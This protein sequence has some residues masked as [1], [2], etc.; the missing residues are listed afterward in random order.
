MNEYYE[1]FSPT[2]A[3]D[4]PSTNMEDLNTREYLE[5]VKAQVFENIRHTPGGPAPS[6]QMHR[7]LCF[8]FFC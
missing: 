6:V 7:A 4:V 5:K 8:I 2:Y 1:Y 3:L